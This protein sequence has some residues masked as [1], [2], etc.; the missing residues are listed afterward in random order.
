MQIVEDWPD[1][2][3]GVRTALCLNMDVSC[4]LH[5]RR[6]SDILV[7]T[8]D[9]PNHIMDDSISRVDEGDQTSEL[10]HIVVVRYTRTVSHFQAESLGAII[11][12]RTDVF[13]AFSE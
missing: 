12:G 8:D 6:L 3:S 4:F 11:A 10:V 9:N 5:I 2:V 7:R 13:K 1:D